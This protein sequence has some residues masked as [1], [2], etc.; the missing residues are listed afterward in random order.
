MNS[1]FK[2]EFSFT[3]SQQISDLNALFWLTKT[4]CLIKILKFFK[5]KNIFGI[6]FYWFIKVGKTPPSSTEEKVLTLL[7]AYVKTYCSKIILV[8]SLKKM[9]LK[10]TF[11]F[12][13]F[14]NINATNILKS[15][16]GEH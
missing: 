9:F 2:P 7:G 5:Q 12:Y 15:S 11:S 14:L 16:A 4:K 8:Y 10:Q 6:L 1:H 3:S 13:L